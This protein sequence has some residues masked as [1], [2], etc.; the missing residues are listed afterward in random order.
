MTVDL[1][2]RIKPRV[3]RVCPGAWAAIITHGY[4]G[5]Y[6]HEYAICNTWRQAFDWAYRQ[7]KRWR[8]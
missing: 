6:E 5:N 4:G 1:R 7:V 3:Y 2:G 8:K